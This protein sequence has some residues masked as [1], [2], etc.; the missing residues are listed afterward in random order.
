MPGAHGRSGDQQ[1]QGLKQVL[2]R[3]RLSQSPENEDRS[4]FCTPVAAPEN[5]DLSH[6]GL[7]LTISVPAV[8]V[9]LFGLGLDEV[10]RDNTGG[11]S[12]RARSSL[13]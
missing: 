3:S 8:A 4:H 1:Q 10:A 6:A 13:G 5:P 12:A 11:Q 7:A 9:V 2:H